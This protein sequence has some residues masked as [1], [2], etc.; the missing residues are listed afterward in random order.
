VIPLDARPRLASKAR[1]RRDRKSGRAMLLYPERG[2]A[3]NRT[4]EEVVGLCTGET[5]VAQMAETLAA[6]HGAPAATVLAEIRAFL[7]TLASRGLLGGL[8]S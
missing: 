5:T 2:L 8:D 7:E 1:V 3:L 6:R 4:A